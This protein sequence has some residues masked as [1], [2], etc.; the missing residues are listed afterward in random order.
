MYF[1]ERL[2]YRFAA[3]VSG[4][5]PGMTRAFAAKGV[6]ASKIFL[7]PNWQRPSVVSEGV[8]K[9]SGWFRR[10]HG[11]PSGALLAVYSGNLGRKQGLDV[12]IDAAEILSA[13]P[14]CGRSVRIVIAGDGAEKKAIEDRLRLHPN[15]VLQVLPLLPAEEYRAMLGDADVALVPQLPGTGRVCFPSKLLSVLGAGLP[16]I[17]AA[18]EDSDLAEAVRQGGFGMNVPAADAPAL[19]D[20]L[21]TVAQQPELAEKWAEQTRWVGQFSP[22]LMLAKFEH[23]LQSLTKSGSSVK[24]ELPQVH[25]PQG[26]SEG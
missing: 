24:R 18:D 15:S 3:G 10:T 21:R 26:Y 13:V 12:L 7:L 4:I 11:I 25:S 8:V 1:C 5:S 17:T 6:P 22:E 23:A 16:V 9:A 2:A 14:P 20:A 19:A